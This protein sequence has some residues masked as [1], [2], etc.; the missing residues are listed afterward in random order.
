MIS[1][2]RVME[3]Q[4]TLQLDVGGSIPTSPLHIFN[5]NVKKIESSIGKE[6]VKT[7]HYSHGIHNGPM[8][9]GLFDNENLIGVCAFATPCSEAV[10]ASVFGVEYKRSVTELHRL[11]LLDEIPKNAESWFISRALKTLKKDRPNYNAVLSFADAT[12]NHLGI[13]YQATNAIYSGTSGK[14]TFFLDTDGRLRHPRQNGINITK[15]EAKHRGWNPVK[16]EGKHRYLYLL[17]NNKKHKKELHKM[18]KL[19]S[20]PYPKEAK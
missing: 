9:Y 3:T 7:Y 11:V 2:D 13:I 20:L 17:A 16:R 14:A 4:L 5:Y 1:G 15:E 10:C 12:Q 8:C 6:F 18:L 19:K